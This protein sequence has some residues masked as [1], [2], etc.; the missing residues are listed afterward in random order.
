MICIGQLPFLPLRV[1]ATAFA[2]LK[3]LRLWSG[4]VE[5]VDEADGGLTGEGELFGIRGVTGLE[6]GIFVEE[7]AV[8][9]AQVEAA[10]EVEIDARAKHAG[11]AGLHAGDEIGEAIGS[12]VDGVGSAVNWE[13]GEESG[14]D[15]AE[16]GEV[17]VD[18]GVGDIGNGGLIH[19]GVDVEVAEAGVK[20]TG[21]AILFRDTGVAEVDG[22]AEPGAEGLTE[23]AEGSGGGCGALLGEA[24]RVTRAVDGELGEEAEGDGGVGVVFGAARRRSG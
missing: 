15:V 3:V 16:E 6:V 19:V 4:L 24:V 10:G 22:V 12:V 2:W 5:V 18:G 23:G 14:A 11:G 7:A 13:E 20:G 8:L 17:L 9:G 1:H 21:V